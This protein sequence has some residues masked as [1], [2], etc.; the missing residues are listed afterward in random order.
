MFNALQDLL[1]EYRKLDRELELLDEVDEILSKKKSAELSIEDV[2]FSVDKSI[3][4]TLLTEI[5]LALS[6]RYTEIH[7][8]LSE[9][10]ERL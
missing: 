6:S 1:K 10:E 3:V 2:R 9:I 7:R 4:E 5:R 8:T